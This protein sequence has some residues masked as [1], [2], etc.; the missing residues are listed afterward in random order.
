MANII[1]STNEGSINEIVSI[2]EQPLKDKTARNDIK[3]ITNQINKINTQF[4]DIEGNQITLEEDDT[5]FYGVDDTLHDNL[6]TTDKRIIGAINE[7][8]AQYK[9]IAHLG[10]GDDLDF[11]KFIESLPSGSRV[12]VPFRILNLSKIITISKSNIELDFRNSLINWKGEEVVQDGRERYKGIITIAGNLLESTTKNILSL[13]FINNVQQP[14]QR[15]CKVVVDDGSLYNIGDYVKLIANTGTNSISNFAP[16]INI[17]CRVVE[18]LNNNIYLDYY[19]PFNF[20]NLNVTGTITKLEPV[21]NIIIKN[22]NIIDTLSWEHLETNEDG[23]NRNKC[24]DGI[25]MYY[26]VN[27]K[28]ENIVGN[29]MKL[30]VV[31]TQ[32]CY[33]CNFQNID[34]R[35]PN[36][37]GSGEG[38]TTQLIGSML[39]HFD[40]IRGNKERHIMD[41]TASAYCTAKNL[42]SP[43]GKQTSLTFH[44]MSEHDIVIENLY[45]G[46]GIGSGIDNFAC[47][48]ANLIFKNVNGF[49][50]SIKEQ[51]LDNLIIENSKIGIFYGLYANQLTIK[52][53]EVQ[54][55]RGCYVSPN[56]R[57]LTT[58]TKLVMDNCKIIARE[59]G[60]SD[61]SIMLKEYD[62]AIFEK[63]NY[64][65]LCYKYTDG[66]L[67]RSLIEFNDIKYINFENSYVYDLCFKINNTVDS[68]IKLNNFYYEG[69]NDKLDNQILLM[70]GDVSGN[71]VVDINNAIFANNSEKNRRILRVVNDSGNLTGDVL[72]KIN[73]TIMKGNLIQT[74][75]N[76]YPNVKYN[77]FNNI[78]TSDYNYLGGVDVSVNNI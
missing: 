75:L 72:V 31:L 10:V 5:S 12:V 15:Y 58:K 23:I 51:Y 66:A 52:D 77:I 64:T 13:N 43:N 26:A 42:F 11:K 41:F 35:E 27:C 1:K 63:I 22:V 21:E 69:A 70:T 76:N 6:T 65:D 29:K 44:G 14:N 60:Y 2:N 59:D 74:Y 68:V 33:N 67:L 24:V 54:L 4:K 39:C 37:L 16:D 49:V 57:N 28:I 46:I 38:Y 20:N 32:Y 78:V 55:R 36:Y 9:D 56:I 34:S 17:C 40:N 7:V 53:S 48:C 18:K 73:N 25:G 45:G 61:R 3:N 8:N 47:I 30:P 50:N 71:L 19:S 62:E